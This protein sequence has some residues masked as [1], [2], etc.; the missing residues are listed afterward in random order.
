MWLVHILPTRG[1]TNMTVSNNFAY[2]SCG[3]NARCESLRDVSCACAEESDFFF[4][5]RH[6]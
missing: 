1:Q 2:F 4:S 5:F 6:S 3:V